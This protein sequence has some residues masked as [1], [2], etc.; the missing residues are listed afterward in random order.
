VTPTQLACQDTRTE[1]CLG[2]LHVLWSYRV[3]Q[4]FHEQGDEEKRLGLAVSPLCDRESFDMPGSQSGFLQY[5][6]LPTWKELANLEKHMLK[7]TDHAKDQKSPSSQLC[8]GR[9]ASWS[10]GT[11]WTNKR[12]ATVHINRIIPEDGDN[13]EALTGIESRTRSCSNPQR[14]QNRL[15]SGRPRFASKRSLTDRRI[16]ERK[17]SK[18][19]ASGLLSSI[20]LPSR[21]SAPAFDSAEEALVEIEPSIAQV[22]VAFCE[23]NLIKW[24]NKGKEMQD[25]N[26][27]EPAEI[28]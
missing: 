17:N 28:E 10:S 23:G 11:S 26:K 18:E 3:V 21:P 8:S 16:S 6:C 5:V 20:A 2:S 13:D 7:Q 12:S 24:R 19:R 27:M 25:P 9:T 22:C 14:Q 15:D 1:A 4:E